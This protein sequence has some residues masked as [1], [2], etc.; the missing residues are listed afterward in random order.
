MFSLPS[1]GKSEKAVLAGRGKGKPKRLHNVLGV[2]QPGG[3]RVNRLGIVGKALSL[4]LPNK[5]SEET[6]RTHYFNSLELVHGATGV[7]Q[8]SISLLKPKLVRCNCRL[9]VVR[10][11]SVFQVIFKAFTHIN[12]K[13][14][15]LIFHKK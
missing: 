15:M 6:V 7:H 8:K 5:R 4:S 11:F 2:S 10:F 3:S 1:L 13:L 9:V 12:R 14:S